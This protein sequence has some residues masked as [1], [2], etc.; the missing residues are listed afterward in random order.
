MYDQNQAAHPGHIADPWETHEEYSGYMM[1]EH[2]PEILV[3]HVHE[4]GHGQGPVEAQADHVVPP[5]AG[6][7]TLKR[8]IQVSTSLYD[9]KILL[10]Y[11]N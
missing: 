4:L 5:Y 6:G 2:L 9:E 8:K 7:N 11:M 1:D 10:Q 3:L